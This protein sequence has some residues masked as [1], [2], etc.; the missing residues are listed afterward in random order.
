MIDEP[1]ARAPAA[2]LR[3]AGPAG[4]DADGWSASEIAALAIIATA[5]FMVSVILSMLVPVLPLIATDTGSSATSTEWLLTSALLAAAVA[6]P[7]AGRLGDLFGKR[8]ML[9]VS[10]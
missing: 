4:S 8:L 6:V 1:P 2:D 7:I 9:M 3:A 5:G 10:A